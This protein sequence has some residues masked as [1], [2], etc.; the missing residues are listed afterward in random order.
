MRHVDRQG[1]PAD[2]EENVRKKGLRHLRRK[3]IALNRPLPPDADIT[4]YWRACL[5]DLY[6]CY[7]GI[8]AYLAVFFE[9]TT[10]GASVDH[11]VAKSKLAGLAYEWTNYRLAC[12]TMNSRKRDYEDV[13][14]PFD[15]VNGW[16]RLELISGRVYPAPDQPD[17]VK[18]RVE[19]TIDRLGLDDPGN[20][21]MRARH[22]LEYRQG[23]Y[24]EEFLRRRSPFV[25]F[26]AERQG[27]L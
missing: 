19:E 6:L 27:L 7:G 16:F 15:V 18:M 5:D 22:Y 1:P 17:D 3:G 20:R 10:G 11:F 24:N 4:P 8:C 25:W 21:E 12:S 26:E 9:R 23:F 14:D 2:F 13:L